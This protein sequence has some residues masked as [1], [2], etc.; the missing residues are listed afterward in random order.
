MLGL[1]YI[2]LILGLAAAGFAVAVFMAL[3]NG[4]R[5]QRYLIPAWIAVF[6][7]II[8]PFAVEDKFGRNAGLISMLSGLAAGLVLGLL[9]ALAWRWLKMKRLRIPFLFV[10]A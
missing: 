5:D 8:G 2:V 3:W 4:L 10:A 7:W 6:L 1:V 9:A